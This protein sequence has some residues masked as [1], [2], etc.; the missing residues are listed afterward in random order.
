MR[1]FEFFQA[2]GD[3]ISVLV[4]VIEGQGEV[5][6]SGDYYHDKINHF[7]EGYLSGIREYDEVECKEYRTD[8]EAED[9]F[10]WKEARENQ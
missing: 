7:V 1:K 8:I 4:E 2:E 10:N 5:T 9:E 3:G 6:M